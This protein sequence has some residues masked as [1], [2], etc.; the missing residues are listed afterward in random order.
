MYA[1][2]ELVW[3]SEAGWRQ[4]A[5]GLPSLSCGADSGEA[6]AAF[7]AWESADWPLVVRRADAGLR[8]GEVALGLALPPMADGRKLR[9]ACRVSTAAVRQR[10]QPL[11][12]E[13]AIGVLPRWR[14]ALARLA[15][16]GREQG[17]AI[18]VYGSVALQVLTGQAYLTE[19]SDIDVLLRPRSRGEL[20]AALALLRQHAAALPLDG[21][22]VFP[23]ARAVAWKEWSAVCD[24]D[25]GTRVLVKEMTRVALV[26]TGSL[27]ATLQAEPRERGSCVEYAHVH[28]RSCSERNG[29]ERIS[30]GRSSRQ[31]SSDE[32]SSDE[33]GNDGRSSDE[34][35]SDEWHSHEPRRLNHA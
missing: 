35:S 19:G 7:A 21:E 12:L 34:R 18:G 5:A 10:R 8:P 11:P 26:D 1:R 29:L 20:D 4:A 13:R 25:P 22:I 2:H 30:P 16:Q 32:Q 23:G 3:L 28:E 6:A 24:A 31:Q 15:E 14:A 27:L 17:L 33:L 9:L